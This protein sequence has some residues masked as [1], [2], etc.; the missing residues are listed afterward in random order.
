MEAGG[1]ALV[2]ALKQGALDPLAAEVEA[3]R[4]ELYWTALAITGHAD[5]ANDAVAETLFKVWR[6]IRSLKDPGRFEG[7][8]RQILVN[9]CRKIWRGQR[10]QV[11]VDPGHLPQTPSPADDMAEIEGAEI[12]EGILGRLN[13]G[14]RAVVA[15]RYMHDMALEDI[16]QMLDIP[17]G[18]VKSRLA[19]AHA[20]LRVGVGGEKGASHGA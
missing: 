2:E 3:L 15:L 20:R 13:P 19:R 10:H 12:L 4:R 11:P 18:T 17:I 1:R 6:H 16:G 7:W 9:E 5:D 8:C 14:E